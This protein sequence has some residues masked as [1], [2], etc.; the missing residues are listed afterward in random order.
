MSKA[1]LK[2][3]QIDEVAKSLPGRDCGLC[4]A[5]TCASLAEDIVLGVAF[6]TACMHISDHEERAKLT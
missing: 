1:I 6:R 2:L 3:G 5:P 4:G